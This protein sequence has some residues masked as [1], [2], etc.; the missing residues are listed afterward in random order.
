MYRRLKN[1]LGVS[2]MV[3]A[4]VIS[5]IP[6]PEAQAEI[7]KEMTD[8]DMQV[9]DKTA[10]V[11]TF[12]MNGG[13][14][15]GSYNGYSFQEKTPV[16]VI[17]DGKVI[18]SFP[19]DKH[20]VY[21]GYKTEADIWYTDPECLTKYDADNAVTRSVTLY[22]KWFNITSDGTTLAAKGF[23]ISADGTVLYRYDGEETLVKIPADV[24]TIADNAFKDLSPAVRGI[25]LPAGIKKVEENAFQGINDSSIV[26]LYDSD[27]TASK[28]YGKQLADKYE[29]LV[30]SDY[31]DPEKTEEIV[32]I[33]YLSDTPQEEAA[34]TPE[35]ENKET[36]GGGEE[37]SSGD[38]DETG[39]DDDDPSKG[40]DEPSEDDETKPTEEESDSSEGSETKPT[41]SE[42]DPSEDDETKPTE[43]E[44]DPSEDDETKP[45]EDDEDESD[46]NPPTTE[47]VIEPEEKY[48]VTFD[49][50]AA[51]VKVEQQTVTEGETLSAP[52]VING[53]S[54]TTLKKDTYQVR[55]DDG[56]Q[57][58]VYT[59][60]G[61]YADEGLTKEWDLAAA[62]EDDMTLYAKW[63]VQKRAYFRVTYSATQGNESAANIPG[64]QKLYA[65]QNLD[66]PSVTPSIANKNFKGWYTSA[67]GGSEY[68]SWGKPV[69]A[70]MTLYAHF[71]EKPGT[72]T[73]TKTNTVVFHMNGGGFTGTYNGSSY[74]D[75]ASLT[76]KI[77]A[78]QKI[79]TAVYPENGNGTSSAFKYSNYTTD[80]NWYKDKE[81]LEAYKND[82]A[83]NGDITLYK[84]WYYTSSGFTMSS[85]GN[86]LY[87]YSGGAEEVV[88]PDSVT[89][90]GSDAFSSV[91]GI[92]SIT[93]PDDITEVRENAFSGVNKISKD[94]VITGKTEKAQ[95]M[96][97]KL[98]G[99]Y[100]RLVYEESELSQENDSSVVVTKA[101]SGSI[102]LG[103]ALYGNAGTAGNSIAAAANN[104]AATTGTIALGASGLGATATT[105]TQTTAV[106][107]PSASSQGAAVSQNTVTPA[108]QGTS[109]SS[110]QTSQGT[111]T[112]Q[113]QNA[114][115]ASAPKST[116][117]IKD[118]TPKTGDPLQ[119]RML[120]VC[121]MF[122]VGVLLILTGNG[123][124]KRFSAS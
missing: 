8:A 108:Q 38:S 102:R 99:Q 50:G 107:Q 113:R 12:S 30:Y 9:D 19:D 53:E 85:S 57:E 24:T 110:V 31:L 95:N 59:F 23:H 92:S 36:S 20:A 52:E 115:F 119:Y 28:D 40:D 65:D 122:S 103:A 35:G 98:A 37:N 32:G 105:G 10:H 117:H 29:Q 49:T 78:G 25:V 82:T 56:K 89:V 116:Q 11:V 87:R 17:D 86:T 4:I 91:A 114:T 39:D 71:E 79:T 104:T 51:G 63:D 72:T 64:E 44:S 90:I 61:W 68:T 88:I 94:I 22:K 97:K 46:E 84:K 81:C 34:A 26:Y 124:K 42:S 16:L 100:T 109:G 13:T 75:A 45:A 18:G 60:K 96:A 112:T 76:A 33:S 74:T 93:L 43:S 27:T 69:T 55:T 6:M 83:P 62:V 3:L 111:K 106:S 14:F 80:G 58:I 15:K 47:I 70:D 73:N 120:I 67:S 5:Q 77:T 123:K 48:T 1:I 66:K 54:T 121:A 118:S 101:A 41:E 21:S 2:L 7:M